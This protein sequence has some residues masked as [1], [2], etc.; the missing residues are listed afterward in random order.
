ML[1][2]FVIKKSWL[3]DSSLLKNGFTSGQ[4]I[5]IILRLK[6]KVKVITK[7]NPQLDRRKKG[8]TPQW[9]KHNGKNSSST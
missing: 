3:I 8:G 7:T 5:E 4:F 6:M 1:F 2:I 9:R